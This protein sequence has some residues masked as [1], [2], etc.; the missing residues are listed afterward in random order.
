MQGH[1]TY[2]MAKATDECKPLVVRAGAATVI[3]FGPPFKPV[4]T[5]GDMNQDGDTLPLALALIGSG[6]EKCY[7]LMID[8]EKPPKPT[9]TITDPKGKVVEEGSFEYG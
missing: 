4:V 3:P 9:F 2:L 5:A 6:G 8:G 1:R 7:N